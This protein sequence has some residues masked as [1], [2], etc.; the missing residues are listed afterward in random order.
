MKNI[1]ICLDGT[2]NE[3]KAR[4]A[5]NVLKIVELLAP[6]DPARQT[7]YYDPGVGTFAAPSAWSLAARRL[8][9]LGGLALG[10][11]IRQNLGEAYGY[12]MR[13]WQPG[14]QVFVFGF[15]RGAYTARA[16]CG[17]LYRVGLLRPGS[18]NL[19]PYAVRVYARQPGKDSDLRR[20]EGWRRMDRFAGALSI[21]PDGRS[22]AFP[23]RYLG[24][25]D[26]VKATHVIGRDIHW[27]YTTKLPN[28][29]TIRHAVSIDEKRRPYRESLIPRGDETWFAGVHS[30]IGG[31]FDDGP[32]LGR[33]T[34]RWVMDG[35]VA[36]GLLVDPALYEKRYRLTEA[37]AAGPV[38][39]MGWKWAFALQRRR[40]IP[41][42]A[43]I[44]GSVRERLRTQP[45]YAAKLPPDPVWNDEA[46]PAARVS[47]T[48]SRHPA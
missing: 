48:D 30:D 12:L 19:I 8:S 4:G 9:V 22:L 13:T 33:I 10:H 31:G 11:G 6:I 5:T 32:E 45:G 44:H 38:H 43:R 18:D 28:V 39:R 25:F 24:L 29:R 34:M 26:T 15:S 17:M 2:G 3:V 7:V 23:I 47:S 35:A 36:E 16:L 46:W 27:P 37:D 41:P 40:P 20:T 1:V 42:G 14:D 21:R